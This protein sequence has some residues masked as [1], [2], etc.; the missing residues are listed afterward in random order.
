MRIHFLPCD[1]PGLTLCGCAP[2]DHAQAALRVVAAAVAGEVQELHA[3]GM[4]N[5]IRRRNPGVAMWRIIFYDFWRVVC[6][7]GL[8]LLYRYRLE[9]LEHF[10]REG[11][12]LVVSNHQSHLDPPI[13]GSLLPRHAYYIARLTLFNSRVFGGIISLL[14]TI[15]IDQTKG[16]LEAI[17]SVLSHL[18]KGRAV[19]I[20]AEGSRTH[21]GGINPFKPGTAL[22][23]RR[24]KVPVLP[25]ALEGAFDVW[26]RWRK[27][28]SLGG[29]VRVK[30]G[31]IIPYDELKSV[32]K[33]DEV[34]EFLRAR[35]EDLRMQLRAELRAESGGRYPAPSP[36]DFRFDDP[37][38][39]PRE[40]DPWSKPIL[41]NA[42][43]AR[44]A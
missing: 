7:T 29:K 13:V 44:D 26:P 12:L 21:D 17:R 43:Q 3:M 31:E 34:L 8:R 28:P 30:F 14:N 27:A 15:P 39:P 20:F 38:A 9:G 24:A 35:V 2:P 25:V 4:L 22:I 33:G 18:E 41:P 37:A 11:P 23:L 10:P 19:V 40:P 42:G 36:G 6:L 1:I 5:R 32:G 16:D